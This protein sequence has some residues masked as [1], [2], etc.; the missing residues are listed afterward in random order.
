VDDQTDEVEQPSPPLPTATDETPR[1]GGRFV[2]ELV[3]TALI[4]ALIYIAIR[5][6]ILPYEVEGASM[7]PN[8]HNSDRLLVSRQ[9]Y[10]HVD[11]NGVFGFLPWVDGSSSNEIY[12]FGEPERGDVIVFN[13]PVNPESNKPYIKRIVGLP[14]ERITF[15]DG[16][17]YVDEVKL[18]ETYIDGANT[19]CD[20][21]AACDLAGVEV[22]DGMVFV[23]GDNRLHSEDSREFG[24]VDVD[25]IIGQAIFTN[26]PIDDFGPV[27]GGDYDR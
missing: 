6:L 27:P 22:P 12:P 5:S 18:A 26:W 14:G 4:A 3:E 24:F 11:V 25:R 7:S 8:L 15:E 19:F 20:H 21:Q 13:P 17:V 23:L 1:R 2:R 10:L 9:S 16:Y